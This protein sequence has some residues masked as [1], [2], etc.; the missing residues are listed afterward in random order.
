MRNL[1]A[2][3]PPPPGETGTEISSG[4]AF[5]LMNALLQL[6]TAPATARIH[7]KQPPQRVGPKYLLTFVLEEQLGPKRATEVDVRITR[8]RLTQLRDLAN[9]ALKA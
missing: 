7:L 1:S 2:V 5:N 4:D 8:E 9:E 3:E 6:A